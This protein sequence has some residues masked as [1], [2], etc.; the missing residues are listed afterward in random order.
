MGERTGRTLLRRTG[1]GK[2]ANRSSIFAIATHY[3]LS[4]SHASDRGLLMGQ[5]IQLIQPAPYPSTTEDLNKAESVF[6]LAVRWWVTGFKAGEDPTPN[7]E[8]GLLVAGAPDAV[9]AI[10][11][12]MDI[13]AR[14][15]RRSIEIHCPRCSNV[16]V[17]EQHLLH[18]ASLMQAER[19]VLAERAL[20]TALLSA[21]GA[22]FALGPLLDL[23]ELFATVS[24]PFRRRRPPMEDT[25]PEEA[26]EIWYPPLARLH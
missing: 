16:S 8:Q 5:V 23:G 6:L 7:I 24:L 21:Q 19:G 20:R 2:V 26:V 1:L 15:A 18:A 13:V 4:Q 12:L 3:H 10:D 9:F 25:P 14:T 11:A 22:E 17:D